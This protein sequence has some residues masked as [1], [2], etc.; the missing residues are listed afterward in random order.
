[1]FLILKHFKRVVFFLLLIVVIFSF[2]SSVAA[3]DLEV[4]YPSIPGIESFEEGMELEK[5]ERAAFYAR[6]ILRLVFYIVLG[7]CVAVLI[8]AGVLYISAGARPAVIVS[9]KAMVQRALLGLGILVG[10]YLILYTINPQLFVLKLDIVE[11]ETVDTSAAEELVEPG[12]VQVSYINSTRRMSDVLWGVSQEIYWLPTGILPMPGM[13]YY[14]DDYQLI[15]PSTINTAL[16]PR[17]GLLARIFNKLRPRPVSAIDSSDVEPMIYRAE[18]PL[19]QTEKI[20]LEMIDIVRGE[21]DANNQLITPGLEDLLQACKCGEATSHQEWGW[22]LTATDDI[23]K[24]Y[25]ANFTGTCMGGM[26][27][28][29]K[30]LFFK[31]REKTPQNICLTSCDDCGTAK[32][33]DFYG[34]P[35][36]ELKCDLRE[37]VGKGTS[38]QDDGTVAV[39]GG[40][41]IEVIFIKS[42]ENDKDTKDTDETEWTLLDWNPVDWTPEDGWEPSGI[43]DEL[44]AVFGLEGNSKIFLEPTIDK[45]RSIKYKRLRLQ[46]L[47]ARLEGQKSK[48]F[49]EQV[50]PVD[51]TL[52]INADDYLLFNIADGMFQNDFREQERKWKEQGL[53]VKVEPFKSSTGALDEK[54]APPVAKQGAFDRFLS[55]FIKPVSAQFTTY[56]SEFDIGNHYFIVYAPVGVVDDKVLKRNQFAYREAGRASLFSVLTDLSLEKIREMFGRCLTSAFGEADYHITDE[57][58]TTVLERALAGGAADGFIEALKD[59][60]PKLVKTIGKT[61]AET[62]QNRLDAAC[63]GDCGFVGGDEDALKSFMAENKECVDPCMQENISPNFTSRTITEFLTADIDTWFGEEVKNTLDD[64]IRTLLGED[65]NDQLNK[66]MG[67]FYDAVLRGVLSQSLEEKIPGLQNMLG[68]KLIELP[69]LDVVL[70]RLKAVDEFLT[71][72][73]SGCCRPVH[74][75]N[76]CIEE[77]FTEFDD[78]KIK[79]CGTVTHYYCEKNTTDYATMAECESKCEGGK[80]N[81]HSVGPF[82]NVATKHQCKKEI[83][84]NIDGKTPQCCEQGLR[85]KIDAFAEDKVSALVKKY[86]SDKITERGEDYKAKHPSFFPEYRAAED[87]KLKQGY[88]FK[89]NSEFISQFGGGCKTD[90]EGVSSGECI[91]MDPDTINTLGEEIIV[92][93]TKIEIKE[94]EK[95]SGCFTLDLDSIEPTSAMRKDI[96]IGAGYCWAKDYEREDLDVFKGRS[97]SQKCRE[98]NWIGQGF[99]KGEGAGGIKAGMASLGRKFVGGLITFGQQFIVAFIETTLHMAIQY[100]KVWI[101]DTITAPLMP[102]FKQVMK[103]QD[104]LHKFVNASVKDIL[105]GSIRD[106]LEKN[107]DTLIADMC[108]MYKTQDEDCIREGK[109]GDGCEFVLEIAEYPWLKWENDDGTTDAIKF[110]YKSPI[111]DNFGNKVC[112][113]NQHLHT[114]LLDEIAASGNL[115]EDIAGV[116]NSSIKDQLDRFCQITV[117]EETIPCSELLEMNLA[118]MVFA[119]TPLKNIL[120]LING[121]PREVICG[122]LTVDW[123]EGGEVKDNKEGADKNLTPKQVCDKIQYTSAAEGLFSGS[124]LEKKFYQTLLSPINLSLP[125]IDKENATYK[126]LSDAGKKFYQGYCPAIWGICKKFSISDAISGV[127]IGDAIEQILETGC[128]ILEDT[129]KEGLV[130]K[131]EEGNDVRL[132]VPP[133]PLCPQ[134]ADCFNVP[135]CRGECLS[136]AGLETLQ[137]P[138]CLPVFKQT[139]SG[140]NTLLKNTMAYSLFYWQV[141]EEFEIPDDV[142]RF[143]EPAQEKE[144][145]GEA[146]QWLYIYFPGLVQDIANV[147]EKRGFTAQEWLVLQG[148]VDSNEKTLSDYDFANI[149]EKTLL[150]N[151]IRGLASPTVEN[152]LTG[153]PL[154][155]VKPMKAG[156]ATMLKP[157]GRGESKNFLAKTPFGLLV[158]D[159]CGKIV[160]DFENDENLEYWS[161]PSVRVREEFALGSAP[162]YSMDSL[163]S[164]TLAKNLDIIL[165]SPVDAQ[166]KIPYLFCE[167]LKHSPVEI[168]GLNEKLMTYIRPKQ[169][170]IIFELIDD[171]LK[172]GTAQDCQKGDRFYRQGSRDECRGFSC[173]DAFEQ[174]DCEEGEV[175]RQKQNI[176]GEYIEYLDNIIPPSSE[177]LRYECCVEYSYIV[178]GKPPALNSL[179]TYLNTKTPSNALA[180]VANT[181]SVEQDGEL[182]RLF[183]VKVALGTNLQDIKNNPVKAVKDAFT[184][185][186]LGL[187]DKRFSLIDINIGGVSTPAMAMY[188]NADNINPLGF[189]VIKMKIDAIP[190]TATT[191]AIPAKHFFV[192]YYDPAKLK[193]GINSLVKFLN[194]PIQGLIFERLQGREALFAPIIKT[195]CGTPLEVPNTGPPPTVIPDWCGKKLDIARKD[196]LEAIEKFLKQRP[197]DLFTKYLNYSLIDC[198]GKKCDWAKSVS[199]MDW[200]A[201]KYPFLGQPYIDSLGRK[202]GWDVGL[203]GIKDDVNATQKL[204]DKSLVNMKT[205][206]Q[207]QLN[208]AL[209]EKPAQAVDYITRKFAELIGG[210]TGENLAGQLTGVCAEKDAGGTVFTESACKTAGKIYRAGTI[211]EPAECCD[212]GSNVVCEPRCRLKSAN[213]PCNEAEGEVIENLPNPL[214]LSPFCCRPTFEEDGEQYCKYFRIIPA[215]DDA[216]NRGCREDEKNKKGKDRKENITVSGKEVSACYRLRLRVTEPEMAAILGMEITTDNCCTTVVDCVA[217]QFDEHLRV[218]AETMNQGVPLDSLIED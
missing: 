158:N 9:A 56:A 132:P 24:T 201:R 137:D 61:Y 25:S 174:S 198:S 194:T 164:S 50:G 98:C 64:K 63:A 116:L 80:D 29:D 72:K 123:I 73:I 211:S 76:E 206:V 217:S 22:K 210:E 170:Q 105:P 37:V 90:L 214:A 165:H 218:L 60:T 128:S 124:G 28:A 180:D 106:T 159:I 115:G 175:F 190:A 204:F 75:E 160:Y 31:N 81:C 68:T 150:V 212:L 67:Q 203:F 109:E 197:I 196:I 15:D 27:E 12:V 97:G 32:L 191:N 147:A 86:T 102:Y 215:T 119:F 16:G 14:N 209:I 143:G 70:G 145:E 168:S 19:R 87:C 144:Q 93:F 45:D 34:D 139:C 108:K 187:T 112:K 46:G 91:K 134:N 127:T 62:L 33:I 122:E 78:G 178:G 121:T 156:E 85:Q 36:D 192:V 171:K 208:N 188:S 130:M 40:K 114:T 59:N 173:S 94:E 107:L 207:D 41:N 79:Q 47:L 195:I 4:N 126:G 205:T 77:A 21:R 96:C 10:S 104:T 71:C 110:T 181:I 163:E 7:V 99:T 57:H 52:A 202:F 48:Y 141:K 193:G 83:Y 179:L 3:V 184:N 18:L 162:R 152:I 169:A 8:I 43:G 157:A 17:P 92:V 166:H 183:S 133:P 117:D 142:Y 189:Y 176:G 84:R 100:A 65:I 69:F 42:K 74:S 135:V 38:V 95:G 146:Y 172:R 39:E 153:I 216:A 54:V 44:S 151:F 155:V 53:I 89:H 186:G 111:S 125:F 149:T 88:L 13:V 140:C 177:N 51:K 2:A 129:L 35:T 154:G 148:K 6:Y 182:K 101:E 30:G 23:I 136:D 199:I 20:V 161:L 138:Q 185:F 1:M 200:L 5:G 49:P 66:E 131:D 167:V 103:F 82:R 113:L 55:F 118:E 26:T 120:K 213:K 11:P 58:M